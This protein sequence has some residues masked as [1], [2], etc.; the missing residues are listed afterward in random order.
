MQIMSQDGRRLVNSDYVKQ[1][2]IE[3]IH[4]GT[5]LIADTDACVIQLGTYDN[6]DHAKDALEFIGI[7]MVDKDKQNKITQAPTQEDMAICNGFCSEGLKLS[8]MKKVLAHMLSLKETPENHDDS[9]FDIES[10]LKDIF[11]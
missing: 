8:S 1:F 7:C 4:E 5:R 9:K 2:Y 3:V 11:N 6:V 10:M